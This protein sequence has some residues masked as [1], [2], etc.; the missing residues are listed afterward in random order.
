MELRICTTDS[1]YVDFLRSD[2]RLS[3]VFENKEDR[4]SIRKYIGVVFEIGK[5]KYFAPLSSPKNSDYMIVNGQRTI[6]RDII[7]II[8]IKTINRDGIYELKGTVK[9]SNMIPVPQQLITYYDCNAEEDYNYRMLI[10]KETEFIL[11]NKNRIIKNAQILYNQKTKENELYPNGKNKPGYL[12]NV[13]DFKY[14]EHMHDIY[15]EQYL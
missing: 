2:D 6:R 1:S 3:N 15:V 13:V 9:L 11:R 14:A 12:R 10:E 4:N 8:R 5:Y 7:P